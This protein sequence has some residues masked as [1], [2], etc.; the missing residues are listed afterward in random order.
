VEDVH[1]VLPRGDAEPGDEQ[2]A[3]ALEL[4]RLAAEADGD[5]P[6]GRR[7]DRE[8]GRPV[9]VGDCPEPAVAHVGHGCACLPVHAAG[10][11]PTEDSAAPRRRVW[12]ARTATMPVIAAATET[13]AKKSHAA[14]SPYTSW[15]RRPVNGPSA[16]PTAAVEPKAPMYA[17]RTSSGA[18]P[19]T[20]AWEVGTQSISPNTK[21]ST[22]RA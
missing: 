3:V 2:L 5:G 12:A 16:K 8:R 6:G 14:F 9:S 13:P 18:S 4:V 22:T 11:A 20:I 17:P 19:A 21:I 1:V 15:R 10:Y 7:P